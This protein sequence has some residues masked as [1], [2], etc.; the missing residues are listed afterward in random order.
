MQRVLKFT[1]LIL[2]ILIASLHDG[3]AQNKSHGSG[4]LSKNQRKAMYT[5]DSLLRSFNKSDTSINNLLQ[6]LAQYNITF[7]Q[8]NNN[9]SEG[10]DTADISQQLPSTVKRINKIKNQAETHKSSTLRYL[11]VLR[12]NL[13][14]IQSK[15]EGWQADL[16]AVNSKLIQNQSDLIKFSSDSLLLKTV[17]SDSLLRNTFFAQRKATSRLWHKTDSANRSNLFKVNLL[18][19]RVAIAYSGILDETDQIDSKVVKFAARAVNGEFGYIWAIDPQYND[20]KSA[21]NGTVNLNN[22]QLYYFLKKET[23]THFISLLFL[24]VV[25]SW[26]IYIRK[27][28]KR[29]SEN[30][31]L[32]ADKAN[33]IY[34][35]PII[36]SLLV[37]TAIIPYFYDHPPVIFLE[38]FFITSLILVLILVKKTFHPTLFNALHQLFYVT[39]GYSLSN[40]LIQI[41]NIDRFSI[42]LLSTASV[43]IALLFNKK[44]NEAPGNYPRNTG[45]VLKIFIGLQLLSLVCDISGRFS[46]A[47]IIGTTAV[48]NLWLLISL[49]FV[50]E[51]ITQGLFLQFQTKKNTDSIVSWIDITLLQEKTRKVLNVLAAGL[52]LFFL[53]QNL[54]IDDSAMD[55]VSDILTQPHTVGNS[56]FIFK[57]FITFI[58]V[59]WL[60]SV[61]SKIVSYFYDIAIQRASDID[62]LKKKN[63]TSTLLIR[64]GVLILGFFLAVFASNFSL[65]KL[66]IIISAFGIGIGF[67]LQNIVN[68]LVSGLILAFEKPIQIGD[69]IEVD[70]R[71]GTIK[72]IG[73]RSSKLATSDG[74]EVIIPNGDLISHHVVNWTL[75]NNNRRV[76]LI[77]SVKYGSDIAKVKGLLID[78]LNARQDIMTNPE[79]LVF[80]HNLNGSSVD[81]QILFWAADINHWLALKNH[82]LSDIFTIFDKEGIEMSS[83]QQDLNLKLPEGKT[84]NIDDIDSTN[85]PPKKT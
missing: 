70:N 46:L 78:L 54:N 28:T 67:G 44:V 80:L 55:Y 73:I 13:D 48:Y 76:E 74:A 15:L 23:A 68:N 40:L 79:P 85:N 30:I 37:G 45:F 69:I 47:K 50:I 27:K 82:V 58:A 18:Q 59:I 24:V 81:F 71:A 62:A 56:T 7:N 17:P 77:V 20:F 41:T 6:R 19:N 75:S 52:W 60:S 22:I 72:E 33:Y 66:T 11:F 42:L 25:F 10:L 5:R 36:S 26:I 49:H 29:D 32:I 39:I 4:S 51:I 31:Q 9:L 3:L 16:D 14:H 12:D 61:I 43:I 63:R 64:I 35:Y 38:C 65:D 34:N 1:V 84:I 8:V 21:V 83:P 53:F 57:D 2:I